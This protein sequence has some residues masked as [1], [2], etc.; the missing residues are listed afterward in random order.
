V[1]PDAP[2]DELLIYL[3]GTVPPAKTS[4]Q[5]TKFQSVIRAASRRANVAALMPRGRAGLAPKAQ[6]GWWGWPTARGTYQ[7]LA[8]ELLAEMSAQRQRLEA[9]TARPFHRVY[10]AG[11]SSGAYFVTALLIERALPVD[12]YGIISGAADPAADLT[13]LPHPPVYIGFGTHDPVGAAARSFGARLSRAGF[14]VKVGIHPLPHG[15][16]EIY[17]DEAFAHFR[18]PHD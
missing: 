6:A 14:P 8:G 7:S 5:K 16:A 9:L 4:P 12:G 1:L 3:H 18:A 2:T 17:L 10:L 13:P 11:S 15:T